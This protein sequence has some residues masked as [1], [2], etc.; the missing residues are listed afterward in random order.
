MKSLA[1]LSIFCALLIFSEAFAEENPT[2][3][4]SSENSVSADSATSQETQP[5]NSGEHKKKKIQGNFSEEDLDLMK[6]SQLLEYL[7]NPNYQSA[8]YAT[9]YFVQ[10]GEAGVT[11]LLNYLKRHDDNDK[12]VSAVIYT[13]GR[14][15][16]AA[17]RSV[18]I[19][20]KYLQH[21]NP[22][23]RKTTMAALGKIGRAS[24]PAVPEIAKSLTDE[25]EWARTLALRSLKEIGTAQAKLIASQYEKKL[26]LEEERKN[27]Q[28]MSG[29][30]E[31]QNTPDSQSSQPQPNN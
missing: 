8:E 20:I 17:S 12:K 25:N 30:S 31:P 11:P 18:P 26:K 29:G 3:E 14:I 19:I 9:Y 24:D 4:S 7:A 6:Q 16:P 21:E 28:L 13:L 23:I 15:G 5:E 2:S 27:K 22:D 1:K 10:K